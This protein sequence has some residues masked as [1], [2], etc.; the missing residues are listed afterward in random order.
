MKTNIS[1]KES[2]DIL[3][4]IK[5]S[6]VGIE[7]VFLSDA[8]NRVLAK[9]IIASENMPSHATSAM[10]GYAFCS[11]DLKYF[12]Q[13]G[14]KVGGINRA[15]ESKVPLCRDHE[16]IKTMTGARMPK[17][18][19]MLILVEHTHEDNGIITILPDVPTPK[20][21][22]WIRAIGENYKQGE[23]L[24]CKG[25]KITPFEIG[26]LA[27]LNCV[28]VPVFM[29]PRMVILSGGDEIIELG[30][31]RRENSI[32]SVNHYLLKAIAQMWG[33][34]VYQFPLLKDCKEEIRKQILETIKTCDILITTGGASRG[35]FDYIQEV[36]QEECQM[37][38]RGVRM[39]PG[40]P[41]GFGIYQDKNYVFSLP[42]FPNSCAVT[43]MLFVRLIVGKMLGLSD[44]RLQ[45]IRAK[46]TEDLKRSD[47]RA[48]FRICDVKIQDGRYEVGFWSKKTLQS[49]VI[50]NFCNSSA[51]I[52]LEENGCDISAGEEVEILLLSHLIN[53]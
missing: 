4:S 47:L 41:V 45:G 44:Y 43:F 22:Q 42:G 19:D 20:A 2:L 32:R 25:S 51:L 53:L 24:L 35:D 11:K 26:L 52:F 37:Q 27:E 46:L 33:M 30:E 49:S 13:H 6:P 34:H 18:C 29:R 9:D 21:G 23:I 7:N 8:L 48:E 10:D 38:F 50:N 40:K 15:G 39:K 16:C 14:L 1:Y 12:Q 3:K 5:V 36:L 28:F 17:G 31:E